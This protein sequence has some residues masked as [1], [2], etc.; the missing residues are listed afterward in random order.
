MQFIDIIINLSAKIWPSVY[1]VVGL[2]EGL[3]GYPLAVGDTTYSSEPAA[4]V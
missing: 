1:A 4:P 3:G 2:L